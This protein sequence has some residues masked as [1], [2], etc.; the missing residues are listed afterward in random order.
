[1]VFSRESLMIEFFPAGRISLSMGD[2]NQFYKAFVNSSHSE[3]LALGDLIREFND[4]QLYDFCRLVLSYTENVDL[5][6]LVFQA[7]PV[8][9]KMGQASLQKSFMLL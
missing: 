1:M 5:L 4:D 9:E 8:I 2:L 7:A 6:G 3:R